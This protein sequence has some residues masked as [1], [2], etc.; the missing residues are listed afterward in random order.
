MLYRLECL[1]RRQPHVNRAQP[2]TDAQGQQEVMMY[3]NKYPP[4][5]A[6][7]SNQVVIA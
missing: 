4:T 1:P 6:I 7:E 2:E 5:T 3:C